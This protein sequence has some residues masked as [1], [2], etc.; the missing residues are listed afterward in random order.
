MSK[1]RLTPEIGDAAGELL[2]A[3]RAHYVASCNF[4]NIIFAI[5]GIASPAGRII[6]QTMN[7]LAMYLNSDFRWLGE[8]RGY[9]LYEKTNSEKGGKNPSAVARRM[10][11]ANLHRHSRRVPAT[12]EVISACRAYTDERLLLLRQ[13]EALFEAA[14]KATRCAEP[15]R[16]GRDIAKERKYAERMQT[17]LAGGRCT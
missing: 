16:W 3:W 7:S 17:I 14:S 12:P 11:S 15:R 5:H 9:C 10:I 13:I 8:E 6:D 4:G 1:T 2:K